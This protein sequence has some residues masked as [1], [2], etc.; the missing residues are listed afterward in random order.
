MRDPRAFELPG[1]QQ[2][3]IVVRAEIL[4][5]V[6]DPIEFAMRKEGRIG[7]TRALLYGTHNAQFSLRNQFKED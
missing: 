2:T 3:Q 4:I 1:I 5:A 6:S 7:D